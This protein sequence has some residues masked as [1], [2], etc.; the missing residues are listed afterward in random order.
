MSIVH[1]GSYARITVFGAIPVVLVYSYSN[2]A[3]LPFAVTFLPPAPLTQ[4]IQDLATAA[5]FF[6]GDALCFATVTCLAAHLPY[7][8]RAAALQRGRDV[9]AKCGLPV[10]KSTLTG[11]R[12]DT[13]LESNAAGA[14]KYGVPCLVIRQ[15]R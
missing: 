14:H 12:E 5:E 8:L 10:S 2:R 1:F 11:D 3:F 4:E 15:R 13:R 6:A 9:A 7:P